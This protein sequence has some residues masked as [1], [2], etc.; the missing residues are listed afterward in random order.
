MYVRTYVVMRNK[1]VHA[2]FWGN[3]IICLQMNIFV[4]L[5]CSQVNFSMS[6]LV[7]ARLRSKVKVDSHY[8]LKTRL[9]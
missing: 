1:Y 4:A 9:H 5:F 2:I 7:K 8:K 6:I 3:K